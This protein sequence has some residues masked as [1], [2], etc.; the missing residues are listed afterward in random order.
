MSPHT[1]ACG[2]DRWEEI[3]SPRFDSLEHQ[4]ALVD[5]SLRGNGAVGIKSRIAA[6]EEKIV[7]DL[8]ARIEVLELARARSIK[9]AWAAMA[10]AMGTLAQAIITWYT[11]GGP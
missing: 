6:L 1:N 4:M 7:P 2:P 3:C 8:K 10:I 11:G 9:I 5:E